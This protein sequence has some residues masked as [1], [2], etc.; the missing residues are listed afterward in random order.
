MRNLSTY[1]INQSEIRRVLIGQN[2]IIILTGI[3]TRYWVQCS[4]QLPGLV[5]MGSDS[6]VPDLQG[7][8][9]G[10]G[11]GLMLEVFTVHPLLEPFVGNV[12]VSQKTKTG[13]S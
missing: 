3:G 13:S 11:A 10:A 7:R 6:V 5:A 4:Y 2:W 8:G 1:R 9:G 12:K